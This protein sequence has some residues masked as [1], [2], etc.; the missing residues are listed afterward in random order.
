MTL[1][2][3]DETAA[4]FFPVD[5]SVQIIQVYLHFGLTKNGNVFTRKLAFKKHLGKLSHLIKQI[6]A[7]IIIGTEYVFSIAARMAVKDKRRKVFSWEHHH[8]KE[9]GKSRF[10]NYLLH[11]TYPKLTAVICLNVDEES[12]FRSIGAHTIVIPNFIEQQQLSQHG[13]KRIITIA[14]LSPVKG[15]DLLL[16][17]AKSILKKHPDWHWK[18]IGDGEMK[19][20]AE[21]FIAENNLQNQLLLDPPVNCDL[22]EEYKVS[23]LYVMTSRNECFPMVLLEAM[24]YGLPCIAFNCETGPRHIINNGSNG[25]LVE[26]GNVE[27]MISIISS[28]IENEEEVNKMSESAFQSVERFSTENILALWNQLIVSE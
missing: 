19:T 20:L 9:L 24:S 26:N 6:D 12:L 3:L 11:Y 13:K 23:A 10:W 5:P 4:L 7:G 17:V 21:K 2:I 8:F 16:Q 14:R 27:E 1:L 28:L 25:Y 15:I 22:S 18:L